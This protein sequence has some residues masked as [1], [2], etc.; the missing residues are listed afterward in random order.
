M[1]MQ[2]SLTTGDWIMSRTAGEGAPA[3]QYTGTQFSVFDTQP[4][5][6]ATVPLY[7]C[8][9]GFG[10][11]YQATTAN[12]DGVAGAQQDGPVLGYIYPASAP[13]PGSEPIYRC[14]SPTGRPIVMTPRLADCTVPG[15]IIQG[16]IG[17]AFDPS[18]QAA[19]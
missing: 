9:D 18:V 13:E 15:W 2:Y 14:I 19:P 11:H 8:T 3:Y 1:Q 5:T 10:T 4:T 7:R 17:Y 16:L 12:C 6:V